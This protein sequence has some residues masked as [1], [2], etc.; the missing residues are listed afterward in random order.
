MQA[1]GC[2]VDDHELVEAQAAGDEAVLVLGVGAG[3]VQ[4]VDRP[5]LQ[6]GQDAV[7]ALPDSRRLAVPRLRPRLV[8]GPGVQE[9]QS[10]LRWTR[11]EQSGVDRLPPP[12][13]V[14]TARRCPLVRI[15]G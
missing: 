10:L 15:E 9:G 11:G 12:A 7:Q 8:V 5:G 6:H 4:P 3:V 2:A 13:A 14:N 1:P